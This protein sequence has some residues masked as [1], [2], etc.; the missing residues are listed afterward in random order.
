MNAN[1]RGTLNATT[2][3]LTLSAG[4]RS[5]FDADG[6]ALIIHANADD[7]TTNPTGNSGGRIAC[8]VLT[9]S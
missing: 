6:S 5:V 3:R 9:A 1:G 4:P 2:D 8:G 7:Q